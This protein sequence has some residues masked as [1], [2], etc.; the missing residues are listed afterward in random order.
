[1]KVF[2]ERSEDESLYLNDCYSKQARAS[3]TWAKLSGRMTEKT[4]GV[5]PVQRNTCRELKRYKY[6]ESRFKTGSVVF[7]GFNRRGVDL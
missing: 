1:M 2:T 3:E 6:A 4:M 5:G 7:R